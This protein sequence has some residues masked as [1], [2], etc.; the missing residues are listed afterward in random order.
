MAIPR[1]TLYQGTQ[2]TN[3]AGIQVGN[4]YIPFY[5]PLNL[6]SQ[7]HSLVAS[8]LQ[9]LHPSILLSVL[10]YSTK[11]WIRPSLLLSVPPHSPFFYFIPIPHVNTQYLQILSTQDY[12]EPYLSG[13][14]ESSHFSKTQ[15]VQQ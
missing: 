14:Q 13:S 4:P 10:G 9:G 11:P 6:S 2:W 1:N 7:I 12:Q 8:Y 15:R 3:L 5:L